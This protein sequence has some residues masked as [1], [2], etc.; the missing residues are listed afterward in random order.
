[1]PEQEQ[2]KDPNQ[3]NRIDLQCIFEF[4]SHNQ[5]LP[6]NLDADWINENFG[7]YGGKLCLLKKNSQRLIG[8]PP[9]PPGV[10]I[11]L[12]IL[13][14]DDM[15]DAIRLIH[16][17][18]GHSSIGN[19]IREASQIYWHPELTLASY[20]V[21]RTCPSCQ[22]MK[23]PDPSLGNL[24]PIQPAP[25]LTRWGI[26]HTQV[27][28]KIILNAIEYAT[29]WLESRLVPSADFSNTVPLLIYIINVFGTPKQIISDNAGCF[30]GIEAQ[31]F[32]AKYKLNFTHT[33]PVRPRSNGKVEQAN[34]VLKSIL[35]RTILENR[36][37]PLHSLLAHAVAIYNRRISPSGY[38]P[39]FLLFGT[40]PP[41]EEL[42]YPIYVREP[43]PQEEIKWATEL[44][45]SHAAPISR[46]YVNSMRASRAKVREYL[47]EKKALMRTYVP[48]DWVLR[49][50]QRRHKFEPFYDGPWAISACHPSNTY[51][52]ISPGGYK[53]I[54][55]YN[56]TNLFP[57]YSRDGHPVRSLWYGSQRMLDQDRKRIKSAV[58]I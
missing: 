6:S 27:G 35:A 16:I 34:G 52:L 8:D 14:Y 25:P 29:N 55:R 11:L 41:E 48:G 50:R 26:D 22:L 32:Q 10:A 5:D 20:E 37:Q 19:T 3:L 45:K 44:A 30:A 40:K 21:I 7:L 56:G 13:E 9:K 12:E 49:V 18:Q 42:I 38:S 43:T 46:S 33:T 53:L 31:N 15:V 2:V 51:S 36:L 58:G 57:A 1:M 4:L 39:F 23:P 28:P 47:Q 24:Q 54:N 17:N